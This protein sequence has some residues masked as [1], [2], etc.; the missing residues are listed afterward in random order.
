MAD[1][2]IYR[3]RRWHWV[4]RG[5]Y[6]WWL[7]FS[8][9]WIKWCGKCRKVVGRGGWGSWRTGGPSTWWCWWRVCLSAPGLAIIPGWLQAL[10]SRRPSL[11]IR[12]RLRIRIVDIW[13]LHQM[14]NWLHEAFDGGRRSIGRIIWRLRPRLA[15]VVF[16]SRMLNKALRYRVGWSTSIAHGGID[17][18][19]RV[20]GWAFYFE[21]SIPQQFVGMVSHKA[22]SDVRVGTPAF[23]WIIR[24]STINVVWVFRIKAVLELF[25]LF[26]IEL[27]FMLI[28]RM[29]NEW[30]GQE[31]NKSIHRGHRDPFLAQQ[32]ADFTRSHCLMFRGDLGSP[33]PSKDHKRIHWS[34]GSP[35]WIE[36]LG[37]QGDVGFL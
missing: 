27:L 13:L 31:S 22:M 10:D 6:W 28:K 25:S 7:I 2:F 8:D 32:L 30:W 34:F 29:R 24:S 3:R 20:D 1:R 21:I 11:G 15:H 14:T 17:V 18:F 5:D 33:A 26:E 4:W 23:P 36:S 12:G 37:C 35:I 16:N 19:V 9:A